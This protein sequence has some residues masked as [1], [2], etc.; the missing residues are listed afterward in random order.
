EGRIGD[1]NSLGDDFGTDAV[2]ADDRNF[3]GCHRTVS[4]C[5]PKSKFRGP[6]SGRR[7]RNVVVLSG[8]GTGSTRAV[9]V[10]PRTKNRPRI[11]NFPSSAGRTIPMVFYGTGLDLKGPIVSPMSRR[12]PIFRRLLERAAVPV[13]CCAGLSLLS[14]TGCASSGA[15]VL[16]E[17]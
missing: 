16:G 4:S 14:I 7:R 12:S 9:R 13:V 17:N 8:S 3:G 11:P 15:K 10:D 2:A 1:A 6:R 5:T